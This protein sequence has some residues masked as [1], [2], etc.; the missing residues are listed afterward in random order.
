MKNIKVYG[1]SLGKVKDFNGRP[2]LRTKIENLWLMNMNIKEKGNYI[3]NEKKKALQDDN[4]TVCCE[5]EITPET[6]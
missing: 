6:L 1:G 5:E 3:K 4:L 2:P